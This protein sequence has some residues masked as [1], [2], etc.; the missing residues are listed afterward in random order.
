MKVLAAT[1]AALFLAQPAHAAEVRLDEDRLYLRA[2][3]ESLRS[4]LRQFEHVGVDVRMEPGIDAIVDGV[5]EGD[6][7]DAAMEQ[8]LES[9]NYLLFWD[10]LQ[11][12]AGPMPRLHAIHVFRPGQR[13]TVKPLR[14]RSAQFEV[15]R[16]GLQV[17]EPF[18]RDE[19]LFGVKPGTSGKE[20]RALLALVGGTLVQSV[21]ERGIYRIRLPENSDV[22][23]LV[24]LLRGQG[25]VAVAEPN[26]IYS[27]P[28]PNV[29]AA[30]A[31]A[32]PGAAAPEAAAAFTP[33]HAQQP[34]LA[35]FDSG[36]SPS[37]TLDGSVL[38]RFDAVDPQRALTDPMGHGTQM[39][40]VASGQVVPWGVPPEAGSQRV[41][42]L[43]VRAFDDQ[44]RATSL[45]IIQAL[46]YAVQNGAR[47]VNM[48]WGTESNSAFL[49]DAIRSARDKGLVLVASAGNEP[50]QRPVYPA[51]YD[52]VIAISAMNAD[53][54]LWN[55][56]NYGGFIA[57]AAPGTG[58]F[59]V[60]HNGPP[61]GYA[62][63]S[64]AS[65]WVARAFALYFEQNP[66]ASAEQ[67]EAAFFAALTD[68]G[69]KGSD[70]Y[71][72]RGALD[73]AALSLFLQQR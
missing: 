14:E 62:G 73:S 57:A 63:T 13:R 45:S 38:G 28:P 37:V 17:H 32:A 29:E 10:V 25:S 53:G 16:D 68:A 70:R 46:D 9:F 20:F 4:V 49:R 34:A 55:K 65:A 1:L 39:A 2:R 43:A 18:V 50:T 52:E 3:R 48:S 60:G 23:A 71:F 36:L 26:Y 27:L 15:A 12:P 19:L 42:L 21:P 66:G 47:V 59:P 67:A 44:G 35:L 61:G 54:T 11:G 6:P 7:V 24:R 56:S 69:P 72:G 22:M 8:L 5:M 40:L 64:I 30:R 31:D 41:P 58:V 51:A 33:V